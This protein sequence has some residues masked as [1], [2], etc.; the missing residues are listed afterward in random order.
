MING[1]KY[2]GQRIFTSGWKNYLGSGKLIVQA[3]K[4]YGRKNFYREIVAITYSKEEL[5]RLEIEFIKSHNAVKHKDYYNISYS[6]GSPVGL[7]PSGES[8]KK[9]SDS[10][11]GIIFTEE[12][13][14]HMSESAKG[15]TISLEQRNKTSKAMTG[16]NN[17][18]YG[19]SLSENHKKKLSKSKKGKINMKFNSEQVAEIRN[20][21]TLGRYKQIKLVKEYSVSRQTISNI[22]HYKGAY[23]LI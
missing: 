13:K 22:I 20:K 6:G 21:Y 15:K 1:K 4:K 18:M 17:P 5:D 2:I 3:I 12:H 7:Y 10:K 23:E 8:K 11:K 14:Q 16:D 19:K 9:M